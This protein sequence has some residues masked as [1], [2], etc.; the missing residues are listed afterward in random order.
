MYNRTNTNGGGA[1]AIYGGISGL[2]TAFG[3]T[4]AILGTPFL[5]HWS[6]GPLFAYLYQ[7]CDF[8]T[9][10]ILIIVMGGVQAFILFAVVKLFFTFV[11]TCA[12]MGYA[13]RR[14]SKHSR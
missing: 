8:E 9:A 5:Y 3:L 1:S 7:Y 12:V 4:A 6:Q 2:G 11:A 14:F 13:L 10:Q